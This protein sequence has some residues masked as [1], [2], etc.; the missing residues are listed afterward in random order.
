MKIKVL[1]EH[2]L[3]MFSLAALVAG[4]G[5]ATKE[6]KRQAALNPLF[7]HV[8]LSAKDGVLTLRARDFECYI[9]VTTTSVKEGDLVIEE[10]G[11]AVLPAEAVLGF[12]KNV[13]SGYHV[14]L[15]LP[16]GSEKAQLDW[17]GYSKKVGV[18]NDKSI[19]ALN[20]SVA[21]CSFDF[22]MAP[23]LV[24]AAK[25]CSNRIDPEVRPDNKWPGVLFD[26]TSSGEFWLCGFE[27]SMLYTHRMVLEHNHGQRFVVGGRM[28]PILDMLSKRGNLKVGFDLNTS[29]LHV[30]G[31]NVRVQL[32]VLED[33]YKPGKYYASL[34]LDGLATGK[35]QVTSKGET[36]LRYLLTVDKG[37]LDTAIRQA[38]EVL[39]REDHAVA[40]SIDGKDDEGNYV[41]TVFAKH[42]FNNST[43]SS[44]ILVKSDQPIGSPIKIGIHHGSLTEVLREIKGDTVTLGLFDDTIPMIVLDPAD[45]TFMAVCT[46]LR[47]DYLH[48]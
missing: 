13:Q 3:P 43:A 10:E 31:E 39:N 47:V 21:S 7:N 1:P 16:K 26:L 40:L 36:K 2:L 42:R 9:E 35:H 22:E 19:D 27:R 32:S 29:K 15:T 24:A 41:A 38:S 12:L 30:E 33:T 28:I 14:T 18:L 5:N 45:P 46:L 48:A 4:E 44:Q 6:S 11:S 8:Q 34:F 17:Y 23:N 20:V 25:R 37:N